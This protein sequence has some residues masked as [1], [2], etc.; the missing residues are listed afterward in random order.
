M[1]VVRPWIFN[2]KSLFGFRIQHKMGTWMQLGIQPLGIGFQFTDESCVA[3][4]LQFK[5]TFCFWVWHQMG[6]WM[7]NSTPVEWVLNQALEF[8]FGCSFGFLNSMPNMQFKLN[9]A[10][11]S[12]IVMW[13]CRST[14][15]LIHPSI[16][17]NAS[18]AYDI[19]V[20]Q[21]STL[22]TLGIKTVLPSWKIT[23]WTDQR[24]HNNHDSS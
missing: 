13:C 6:A 16:Y 7:Q 24:K 1:K 3:L 22:R 5:S 9:H 4:N 23:N 14:T 2:S 19:R 10:Y 12:N 17:I 21:Q 11:N 8:S 15:I 20:C 18:A